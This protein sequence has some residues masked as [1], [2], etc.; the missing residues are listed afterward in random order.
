MF[1]NVY[2]CF[3][4]TPYHSL[5]CYDMKP[6]NDYSD[7][8][9]LHQIKEQYKLPPLVELPAQTHRIAKAYNR[10]TWVMANGRKLSGKKL[11]LN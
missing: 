3:Q 10:A 6:T 1:I 2:H 5:I 8:D 7:N 9:F 11:S 4:C